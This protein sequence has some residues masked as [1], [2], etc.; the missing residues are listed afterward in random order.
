[1]HLWN[2]NSTPLVRAVYLCKCCNDRFL[3]YFIPLTFS[4]KQPLPSPFKTTFQNFQT[5][6][7]HPLH[8]VAGQRWPT[9]IQSQYDLHWAIHK[10]WSWKPFLGKNLPTQ[11]IRQASAPTSLDNPTTTMALNQV[12]MV[13]SFPRW[14]P[15]HEIYGRQ[16]AVN[17]LPERS[18]FCPNK[19]QYACKQD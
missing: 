11:S 7:C 9:L 16:H 2:G 14:I 18:M 6:I 15:K 3:K 19:L 8:Q 12:Q 4:S 13:N 5:H 17:L 10:T 1:M